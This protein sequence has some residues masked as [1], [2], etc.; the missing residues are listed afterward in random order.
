MANSKPITSAKEFW[1]SKFGEYPQNDAEKLAVAMM[2]EFHEQ[3][4]AQ[5]QKQVPTDEEI[6]ELSKKEY[7]KNSGQYEDEWEEGF[8]K[9]FKSA[10]QLTNK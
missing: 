1:K 8:I 6:L 4:K 2:A 3:F 10:I 7:D 5:E 9:G